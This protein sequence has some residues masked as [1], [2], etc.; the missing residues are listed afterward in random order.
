MKWLCIPEL[1]RYYFYL[2]CALFLCDLAFD[3]IR[4]LCNRNGIQLVYF[5]GMVSRCD[6][7]LL[8]YVDDVLGF[9]QPGGTYILSYDEEPQN[10]PTLSLSGQPHVQPGQLISFPGELNVQRERQYSFNASVAP[11]LWMLKTTSNENNSI[12]HL[13]VSPDFMLSIVTN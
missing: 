3:L 6:M 9:H 10:E 11:G 7:Y 2:S 8:C 4:S 1:V 5:M 12:F 13:F